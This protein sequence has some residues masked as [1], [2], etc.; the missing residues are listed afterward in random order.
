M[1]YLIFLTLFILI[2]ISMFFNISI[3]FPLFIGLLFF[4][5][6]SFK[7]GFSVK[8][9]LN[10]ILNGGKKSFIV[11]KIFILIGAVMGVWLSSGVVPYIVYLGIRF[12]N[13]KLFLVYTFLIS[14]IASCL[15]GSAFGT[16]GTIGVS[17]IIL[18]KGAGVNTSL[19]AGAVLSGAFF[20][21]RCSPMSSSANLVAN[22]TD[23][24]LYINIK[25]MIKSSIVPTFLTIIIYLVLS[26]NLNVTFKNERL[27]NELK[28]QFILTPYLLIPAALIVVL[29][30]FKVDVK[31]SMTLSIISSILLD[32]FVQNR[33]LA[34]TLK[35]MIVGFKIDNNNLVA[36]IIKGGGIISMLKISVIVFL[37]SAYS[38]IFEETKMLQKLEG[39][40]KSLS[41]K[42]GDTSTTLL[43][44]IL[45]S[46]IGFTQVLAVILTF[47][48][49]KGIY[50]DKYKL[51]LDI[52]NSAI[53]IAPLIPWNIAYAVPAGIMGINDIFLLFAVYLYILPIYNLL[54]K[55][56]VNYGSKQ[57]LSRI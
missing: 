13:P 20:G 15:I 11:L 8:N 9:I 39:D 57:S 4:C 53:V 36:Q 14:S 5:L 23:T 27:I 35:Y 48:F 2:F 25:N 19:A 55:K 29:S 38:G 49:V 12:M 7:M 17:F 37:S 56:E 3:I 51:A 46:M 26:L 24:K 16:V 22:L 44:S 45:A 21:D 6:Y 52:E 34:E 33:S 47:Q 18:A 50:K 31:K 40:I 32:L 1:V 10:M 28:S 43:V 42:I 41:Q 54:K 30:F